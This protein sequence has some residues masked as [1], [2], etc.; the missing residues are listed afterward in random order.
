M[1]SFCLMKIYVFI[2]KMKSIFYF[3]QKFYWY[4]VLHVCFIYWQRLISCWFC[5]MI[6]QQNCHW[7]Q[8]CGK[9]CY[10]FFYRIWA[11]EGQNWAVHHFIFIT[12]LG[13]VGHNADRTFGWGWTHQN[14]WG[15]IL[16]LTYLPANVPG[17]KSK[18]LGFVCECVCMCM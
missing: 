12:P 18:I 16:L 11:T 3:L 6:C 13:I 2:A 5:L 4:S 7:L 10:I 17:R 8:Q 1:A 15:E 9:S 14:T